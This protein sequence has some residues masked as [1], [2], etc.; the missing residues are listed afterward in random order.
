M[1]SPRE[2]SEGSRGGAHAAE[3]AGEAPEHDA[4]KREDWTAVQ[5]GEPAV[6]TFRPEAG[7]TPSSVELPEAGSAQ[8]GA[9]PP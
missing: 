7:A 5:T 8:V 1:R 4:R 9:A 2:V 3:N 6:T